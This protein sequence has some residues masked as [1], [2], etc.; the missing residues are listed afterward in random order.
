MVF[1]EVKHH[2][3]YRVVGEALAG[4]TSLYVVA[5]DSGQAEK[6]ARAAW[7]DWDYVYAPTEVHLV[8]KGHRYSDP[9]DTPTIIFPEAMAIG[10]GSES[11]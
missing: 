6:M 3:L 2:N 9:R 10:R 1:A 4:T 11:S 8:A 7:K 5:Q